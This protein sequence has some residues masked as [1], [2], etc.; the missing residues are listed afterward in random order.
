MSGDGA[1]DAWVA[2]L[3]PASLQL[4]LGSLAGAAVGF[5]LRT[6]AKAAAV[7]AGG[8]FMLVQGLAYNGIVE[9][10]WK[11]AEREAVRQLDRDQDGKLTGNDVR[12]M[13]ANLNEVIRWNVPA[14]SGFSGGLLYGLSGGSF[15]LLAA[16]AGAYTAG[17]SALLQ[18]SPLDL[19]LAQPDI[20]RLAGQAS[21]GQL[22]AQLGGSLEAL[23]KQGGAAVAAVAAA[24]RADPKE[25]NRRRLEALSIDELRAVQYELRNSITTQAHAL[26][27]KLEDGPERSRELLAEIERRTKIVKATAHSLG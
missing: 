14:G 13:W 23:L 9:V 15:K 11:K 22:S 20:K 24:G 17:S 7:V 8:G 4:G 5:T 21:T 10:D 18:Q 25:A 1:V 27:L 16:G 12:S 6:G 2:A 26:G 19:L 3:A